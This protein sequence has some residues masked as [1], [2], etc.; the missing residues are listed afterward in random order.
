MSAP[1]P[2]D[3]DAMFAKL[4]RDLEQAICDLRGMTLLMQMAADDTITERDDMMVE[5]LK[6]AAPWTKDYRVHILTEDQNQGLGFA[7][8]EVGRLVRDLDR[9]YFAGFEEVRKCG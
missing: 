3:A 5:T 8:A 2:N 6:R 9:R 4:Y 7:L 1:S